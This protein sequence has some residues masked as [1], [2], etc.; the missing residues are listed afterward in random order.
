MHVLDFKHEFEISLHILPQVVICGIH[1]VAEF[2]PR[3]VVEIPW[4]EFELDAFLKEFPSVTMVLPLFLSQCPPPC[5]GVA[6]QVRLGKLHSR[7]PSN[8]GTM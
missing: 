4:N 1:K 2:V 8:L 3:D 5:G 7:M 6:F